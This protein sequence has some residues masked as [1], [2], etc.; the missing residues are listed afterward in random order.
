MANHD[1][2]PTEDRGVQLSPAAPDNGTVWPGVA[3]SPSTFKVPEIGK[4]VSLTAENASG[5]KSESEKPQ[6]AWA[7]V[8]VLLGKT[9]KDLFVP[10][11]A[12]AFTW[13]IGRKMTREESLKNFIAVGHEVVSG[14][15]ND[16][17]K[18]VVLCADAVL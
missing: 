14:N 2:L 9:D 18:S 8:V 6:S 12:A 1:R 16:K 13:S 7:S 11:G 15:P 5:G 4:V 3:F 10:D 17:A